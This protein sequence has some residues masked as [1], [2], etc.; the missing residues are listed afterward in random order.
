MCE[1]AVVSGGID[2]DN[3]EALAEF[4]YEKNSDGIGIAAIYI[5]EDDDGTRKFDANVL[6]SEDYSDIS[7]TIEHFGES[8]T[9]WRYVVHARLTTAGGDGWDETHPIMVTEN[10]TDAEWV[11]HNGVVRGHKRKRR[12]LEDDGVEFNT[13][14]DS[15]IIAHKHADLPSADAVG[16]YDPDSDDNEFEQPYIGGRLNYILFHEDR[17]LVRNT[18][19]YNVTDDF[20]I[21]CD[22][23]N[24]DVDPEWDDDESFML[25]TPDGRAEKCPVDTA[26]DY[27]QTQVYSGRS[28]RGNWFRG[29]RN[30]RDSG[31]S[32]HSHTKSG[33]TYGSNSSQTRKRKRSES[34]QRKGN[35]NSGRARRSSIDSRAGSSKPPTVEKLSTSDDSS[36]DDDDLHGEPAVALPGDDEEYPDDIDSQFVPDSWFLL[37]ETEKYDWLC[38]DHDVLFYGE[39]RGGCP[40]CNDTLAHARVTEQSAD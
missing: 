11:V 9:P 37:H 22:G 5:T 36:A 12:K 6:K 39:N 2:G 26:R 13:E 33:T 29:V 17:I 30:G 38:T 10:D 27:T 21:T 25:F 40:L 31:S 4:L 34:R 35:A 28:G 24:Y 15:E 7:D 14:V 16:D 1:I 3:L 20:L 18:G 23:R 32:G 19:K 8:V